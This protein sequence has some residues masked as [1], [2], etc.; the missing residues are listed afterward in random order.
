MFIFRGDLPDNNTYLKVA[1]YS[2]KPPECPLR[3]LAVN[4][5]SW[6]KKNVQIFF[7]TLE[8]VR[9]YAQTAITAGAEFLYGDHTKFRT[10][11]APLIVGHSPSDNLEPNSTV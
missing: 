7:K 4:A 9:I 10:L 8:D 3:S 11:F 6:P 2:E 1:W 5:L